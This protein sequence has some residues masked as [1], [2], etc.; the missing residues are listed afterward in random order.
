MKNNICITYSYKKTKIGDN[1]I[2]TEFPE[3]LHEAGYTFIDK[4]NNPFLKYNPY[5]TKIDYNDD[6]LV[7]L[8]FNK[9]DQE[10]IRKPY[11]INSRSDLLFNY[12][13]I[14]IK[15]KILGPK[16]YIHEGVE[17]ENIILLHTQ[18]KLPLPNNIIDHVL[19]KYSKHYT[20]VQIDKPDYEWEYL[21][22]IASK[23]I[24]FIGTDSWISHLAQA[25]MSNVNV[26]IEFKFIKFFNNTSQPF[27]NS[28]MGNIWLHPNNYYFNETDRSYGF[29]NS[30]LT[31]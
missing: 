30:Y 21:A 29:T 19:T 15:P 7:E 8:N 13:N 28:S 4:Y 6:N 12:L 27:G 17:K 9:L 20:I 25:Y 10:F 2:L 3:N 31:L 16:L 23:S 14:K 24:M 5:V 18:G 1:L 11:N 22:E 26:F